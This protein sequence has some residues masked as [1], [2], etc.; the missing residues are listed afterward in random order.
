MVLTVIVYVQM[1]NLPGG[2][3]SQTVLGGQ[4]RPFGPF[5]RLVRQGQDL[6]RD[7]SRLERLSLQESPDR[8]AVKKPRRVSA[9]YDAVLT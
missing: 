2:L 7:P 5:V 6:Q 1:H 4:G 8:P 3:R 9:L